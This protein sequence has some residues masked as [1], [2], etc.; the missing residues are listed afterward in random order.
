MQ[1]LTTSEPQKW[2][3]GE[4]QDIFGHA[5]LKYNSNV[6]GDGVCLPEVQLTVKQFYTWCNFIMTI[7]GQH[8]RVCC[9]FGSVIFLCSQIC[10]SFPGVG[11]SRNIHIPCRDLLPCRVNSPTTLGHCAS[12]GRLQLPHKATPPSSVLAHGVAIPSVESG[13]SRKVQN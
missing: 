5:Y 11:R 7:Q 6:L 9:L 12:T 8:F 10:L 4:L 1:F 13:T 3:T 2:A